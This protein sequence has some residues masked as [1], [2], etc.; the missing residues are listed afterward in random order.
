MERLEYSE[1]MTALDGDSD[2]PPPAGPSALLRYVE[3]IPPTMP[4]HG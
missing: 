2:F 3:Q 1:K 4:A